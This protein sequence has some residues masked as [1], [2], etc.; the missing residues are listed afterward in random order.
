MRCSA[1]W[2]ASSTVST[3]PSSTSAARRRPPGVWDSRRPRRTSCRA[4]AEPSARPGTTRP[5][6]PPWI[7]RSPRRKPLVTSAWRPS[8]GS[9]SGGCCGRSATS[10]GRAPRSKRPPSGTAKRGVESRLCSASASWPRWTPRRRSPVPGSVS[11]RS[12]RPP[13][14]RTTLPSRSSPSTRSP[15]SGP[16]PGTSRRLVACPPR[17][18]GGWPPPPTSSLISIVWTLAGCDRWPEWSR[19]TGP[20]APL[21]QHQEA[22]QAAESQGD[23]GDLLPTQRL[24]EQ[25]EGPHH[26][27]GGLNHLRDADRAD[28]DRLLCE[29]QKPVGGDPDEEGEDQHVGPSCTAQAEHV[30]VGDRQGKHGQGGDRG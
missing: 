23:P 28:L 21:V 25:E 8:P 3:T 18:T 7:S 2:L 30:P 4:W 1:S 29:H 19:R 16:W 22:Q 13:C 26:G 27:E 24:S 9:T 12:S 6:R 14:R 5:G 15:G 10:R 17:P 11:R 20:G